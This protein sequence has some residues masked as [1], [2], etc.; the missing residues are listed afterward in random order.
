MSNYQI[1]TWHPIKKKWWKA[2]WLDNYFGQHIYGVR[3][4]GETY[5]Y[6][7]RR[8]ELKTKENNK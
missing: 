7:P 8:I 6:D 1:M 5:V 4:L 3:F 2:D